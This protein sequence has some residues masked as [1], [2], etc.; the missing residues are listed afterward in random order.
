MDLWQKKE[1]CSVYART[2]FTFRFLRLVKLQ[3]SGYEINQK[4]INYNRNK[5]KKKWH[6]NGT[7]RDQVGKSMCLLTS[8]TDYI[9]INYLLN[10]SFMSVY[11]VVLLISLRVTLKGFDKIILRLLRFLKKTFSLR[12]YQKCLIFLRFLEDFFSHGS[13][14]SKI[15]YKYCGFHFYR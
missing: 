15:F 7:E 10:A 9:S 1:T 14:C 4:K 8:N 13:G 12:F 11:E 2:A 5:T 6:S 3:Q